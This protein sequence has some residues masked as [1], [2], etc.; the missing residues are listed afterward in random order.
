MSNSVIQILIFM[1]CTFSLGLFLGWVLWR[2]GGA[3]K[4]AL[5]SMN[6]EVEFWRNNLEQCRIKLGNEQV[7][8]AALQEEK[9][10]LKK[11]LASLKTQS[12]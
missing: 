2:F 6:T 1:L 11:R 10:N 3:S 7:K 5:D 4:Q 8:L 9:A 12:T